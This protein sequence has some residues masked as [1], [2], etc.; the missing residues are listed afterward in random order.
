MPGRRPGSLTRSYPLNALVSACLPVAA[1][2][3]FQPSRPVDRPDGQSGL[4]SFPSP[5]LFSF[6]PPSSVWWVPVCCGDGARLLV[7]RTAPGRTGARAALARRRRRSCVWSRR[8]HWLCC[9]GPYASGDRVG[10]D[11]LSAATSRP[12]IMAPRQQRVLAP[13]VPDRHATTAFGRKSV[14]LS[15]LWG[16]R[17]T[18]RI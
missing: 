18:R 15:R 11:P 7:C 10:I 8:G 4:I 9:P 13:V 2:G 16:D 17:I 5:D 3:P 12:V 1:A 14:R 6:P